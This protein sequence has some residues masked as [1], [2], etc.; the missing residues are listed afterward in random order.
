MKTMIRHACLAFLISAF[1]LPAF[2]QGV[3]ITNNPAPPAPSALL[4]TLGLGTGE[5]N[6]LFDGEFKYIISEQGDPPAS[7]DG[8]R[9]MWYPDKAAFRAGSVYGNSWDKDMIGEFSI[10]AGQSPM[11]SGAKAVALGSLNNATG[12]HSFA[13]GYQTN[14]AGFNSFTFGRMTNANGN[15]TTAWGSYSTATGDYSTAWGSTT[16]ATGDN[17]T[18]WGQSTEAPSLLETVFGRFNTIYTPSGGAENWSPADRL[19]VIGNG[20][21]TTNRS[22]AFVLMKSGDVG[23]GVSSPE[24]RLHIRFNSATGT[25][26]LLVEESNNSSDGSRISF[27]NTGRPSNFW[28]LYGLTASTSTGAYFN[29]FYQG[30]GDILSLR[31]NGNATL[32]GTLTQN[33]DERLKENIRKI[34]NPLSL[35]Q[36]LNG[37]QYN[38]KDNNRDTSLQ[39]GLLAQE[40]EKV[41]PELVSESNDGLKGVNYI[42]LIPYLLEAVK[43]LKAEN[44]QLKLEQ[45][46]SIRQLE[47]RIQQLEK[48]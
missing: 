21:S 8:T 10:A 2:A 43:E 13:L 34:D 40:V 11:A 29:I 20:T 26:H 38:W 39:T 36:Q 48:H 37:Y 18:V 5:G 12:A 30:I 35:L 1:G 42:G 25:G 7:G 4:H 16:T 19:F 41:F 47:E 45:Q 22:D 31:G 6:V 28:D 46:N 32:M 14:A 23:I 3:M 17:T 15:Y 33:S 27:K 24:A 44:E 9:M